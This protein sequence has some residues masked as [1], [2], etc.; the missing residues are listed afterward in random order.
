MKNR[1]IGTLQFD[2]DSLFSTAYHKRNVFLGESSFFPYTRE[3]LQQM[4]RDK[5]DAILNGSERCA[6]IHVIESDEEDW[7]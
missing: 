6:S 2:I 5:R 7:E 1:Q 4:R 3:Q